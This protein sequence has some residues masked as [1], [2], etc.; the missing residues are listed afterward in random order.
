MSAASSQRPLL[1]TYAQLTAIVSVELA[2]RAHADLL[3]EGAIE[4]FTPPAIGEYWP[5]QGG[6]YAGQVRE[7]DGTQYHLILSDVKP[8]SRLKWRAGL[9]WAKT[10]SVDGHTDFELPTRRANALL[11]ANLSDRF[12]RAWHWSSTE[13]SASV[14][15]GCYFTSG[16][17]HGDDEDYEGCCRA[18][19]RFIA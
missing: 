11:F 6:V 2:D 18:V 8:A 3:A 13:Y 19:R 4:A 7:D 10:V 9:A 1:V 12:E 17:Q 14:A 16:G 15:W 5:G